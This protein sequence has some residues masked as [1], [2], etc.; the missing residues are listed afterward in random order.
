MYSS[1]RSIAS[2]R[3]ASGAAAGSGTRSAIET[4]SS[5]LVPQVSIGAICEA[6][7]LTSRSKRLPASL[8]SERQ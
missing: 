5:G 3:V 8:G 1:E 2:R 7:S 4:A 6:S